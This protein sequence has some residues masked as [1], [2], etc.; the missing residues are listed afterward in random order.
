[1]CWWEDDPVQYRNPDRRGGA[2]GPGVN[3]A[4]RNYQEIG[5][6]EPDQLDRVRQPSLDEIPEA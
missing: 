5:V 6:S 4:P 2:N 1:V 3:E